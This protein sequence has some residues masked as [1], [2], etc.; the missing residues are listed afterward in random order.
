MNGS[1]ESKENLMGYGFFSCLAA[2]TS[3][4]SLRIHRKASLPPRV[5]LVQFGQDKILSS[6]G[7][8][9]ENY[10]LPVYRALADTGLSRNPRQ[11]GGFD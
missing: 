7:Y 6:S 5:D 10:C 9:E 3:V 8:E 2:S 1:I 11:T 4:Y